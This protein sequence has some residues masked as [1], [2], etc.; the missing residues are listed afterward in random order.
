MVNIV[1]RWM[2]VGLLVI[3]YSLPAQPV[4]LLPYTIQKKCTS[5]NGAVVAAHPLAS[6]A[7]LAM[8]KKGGNAFDAFIA[9]QWMLGVVYPWAGTVGGGGFMVARLSNGKTITLDFRET[10]PAAVVKDMYIRDGKGDT[11]LSQNGHIACGVPSMVAGL[12]AAHKYAKL[13]MQVLMQEAIDIAS[14]GFAITAQEAARLNKKKDDFVKNNIVTPLF[15]KEGGWKE[16][17]ILI[18]KDLTETL[19]RIQQYGSKGFYEGKT[20]ALIAAEMKKAGG[21]ITEEDL[22]NYKI[23]FREPIVFNYKN[24]QVISMGLP[25][26]G[27][28]L[29]NQ[30]LKM[31]EKKSIGQMGFHSPASIHLMVETERRAYADRAEYMGDPDFVNVPVKALTN[32][33]YIE[34][35][36]KDYD[37]GRAT[38]SSDIKAGIVSKEKEET[39]HLSCIDKWGNCIAV[40]TTLNDGYGSGVVIDGTGIIMSNSMDDFSIQPGV[41]NMFGA[42]GGEAN[43]IAPN[44]RMLSSMSPTV[45]LKNNNPFLILGTPG[46]TTIPTSVYQVILN[47]IEFGLS[48]EDAV[49]SLRF[50]H[51]WLPDMVF[52]EKGFPEDLQKQLETMGHTVKEREGLGRME[53]I[54]IIY[55]KGR[56]KP[57]FEAVGDN[58]GDDDA[59]GY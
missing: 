16:G 40:T 27:G 10:A 58:R 33:K 39:T 59:E 22:K 18:Q 38:K 15:V 11:K 54:K 43:A 12:F 56:P 23:K 5:S 20:A 24:Y 45:I 6:K 53:V 2:T 26:S 57:L 30:M 28:I 29:L 4:N 37:P 31:V 41:P 17:D 50:H 44:K 55:K 19:K 21:L 46:G 52:V 42:I 32:E 8:L 13:P 47:I 36:I 34:E 3:T 35:R 14:N 48:T 51:Q 9:T 1:K 7:G 49:N 25:S